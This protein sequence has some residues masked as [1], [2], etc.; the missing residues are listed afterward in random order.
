MTPNEPWHE[1]TCPV[2][3]KTFLL[4]FSGRWAYHIKI[5]CKKNIYVC[6]WK[7]QIM[8]EKRRENIPQK[9]RKWTRYNI[10]VP[11]LRLIRLKRD[12]GVKQLADIIGV[13]PSTIQGYENGSMCPGPAKI[14]KLAEVLGCTEEDLRKE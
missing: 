4:P 2:C 9:Q 13:T 8:E 6:S 14:N 12:L 1:R 5:R 11:G 3:G 7:C 10:G